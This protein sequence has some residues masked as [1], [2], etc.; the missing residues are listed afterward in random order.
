MSNEFKPHIG[1]NVIETLTLGMYE[2]PRFIYREYVQNAADQIDIAVEQEI[3]KN[4][5]EGTIKIEIDNSRNYVSIEDNA[6]GISYEKV[7]RFLGD[8]A[9][10]EKDINKRKGFRGI[11]R[12]GGLGYCDKLIFET[13]CK[14]ENIKT[15]MTLN[16][17][18]LR[19]IIGNIQDTR[20]ASSVISA[21]TKITIHEETNDSHY[22]RVILENVES[23]EIMNVEGVEKYLSMVAPVPFASDFLYLEKI[24]THFKSKNI[25]FEEYNVEVNAT[26]VFKAYKNVIHFEKGDK[27]D[28]A[29]TSIGFFDI[30]DSNEKLLGVG[31]YGIS[32]KINYVIEEI[33]IERGIR[34]RKNNITIGNEKTLFERFKTERTNLRYIGEVHVMSSNFIPNARRDYFNLNKTL[35]QFQDSLEKIF[36]NFENKLPHIASDL[37]NR[38][39]DVKECRSLIKA[40]KMEAPKFKTTVEQ[41]QRLQEVLKSVSNA[42]KAAT[43][44]EKIVLEATDNITIKELYDSIIKDYD[45]KIADIELEGIYSQRIYPPI[46]FEKVSTEQEVILNEVVIFLQDELGHQAAGKLI[47][48]L[49]KK[50]N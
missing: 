36:D 14:G 41:E 18:F 23:N 19:E 2:D 50:Y 27:K 3:L 5:N 43:K 34:I 35:E 37:H 48:K 12:L 22:F 49:Q 17:K 25:I 47:N 39:K 26:K 38:L 33:N 6:T 40:Y 46:K 16:A 4:R 24:T 9:N 30:N 20:D 8:V 10:S 13:S 15:I 21:I 44:I 32:D 11:G 1:K 29:I 42:S 45:F 7:N 28:A 31:W